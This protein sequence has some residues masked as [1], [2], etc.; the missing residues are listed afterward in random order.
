M[1]KKASQA[2]HA[3]RL[4]RDLVIGSLFLVLGAA[5]SWYGNYH[6]YKEA[7]SAA[8]ANKQAALKQAEL[9]KQKAMAEAQAKERKAFADAEANRDETIARYIVFAMLPQHPVKDSKELQ[10]RVDQY[11]VALRRTKA[12]HRGTPV[13]R[14]NGSIGVDWSINLNETLGVKTRM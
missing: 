10:Q 1:G 13:Y 5:A 14:E 7:Q 9:D 3:H 2:N 12:D 4:G 8:E 11:L 6:Y